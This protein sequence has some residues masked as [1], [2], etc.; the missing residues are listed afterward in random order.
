MKVFALKVFCQLWPCYSRESCRFPSGTGVIRIAHSLDLEAS[1]QLTVTCLLVVAYDP[2]HKVSAT[3]SVTV[4]VLDVNDIPPY[5]IPS[6]IVGTVP[7]TTPIGYELA[8]V[9][10][11]DKDITSTSL[12]Y[13]I[14]PDNSSIGKFS[15]SIAGGSLKAL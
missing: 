15:I 9:N 8:S 4:T 1:P 7:E 11:A 2:L 10:C 6:L 14:V 5:C 13:H 12:T 3:A